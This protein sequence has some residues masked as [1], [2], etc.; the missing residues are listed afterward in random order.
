MVLA[1]YQRRRGIVS[2]GYVFC[3]WF[4]IMLLS[5]PQFRHEIRQFEQRSPNVNTIGTDQLSWPDY[6]FISYMIFFPLIVIQLLAHCIADRKPRSSSFSRPQKP[7]NKPS[8]EPYSGFLQTILF[9][10]FDPM[11][12]TGYRR[13]LEVPDIWDI[14]PADTSAELVPSFD[15]YWRRNVEKNEKSRSKKK[16]VDEKKA[17]KAKEF[18]TKTHVTLYFIN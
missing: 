5:I 11:A 17:A 16:K 18:G 6:Q 14:N 8:P 4:V 7:V 2:S 12:F 9:T 1:L 13:S 3:F 15:E 10:W